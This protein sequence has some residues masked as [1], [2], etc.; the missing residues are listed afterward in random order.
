MKN[1]VQFRG[2]FG[3]G[4]AEVEAEEGVEFGAVVV[5]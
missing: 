4:D 1:C 5:E 3:G 2:S